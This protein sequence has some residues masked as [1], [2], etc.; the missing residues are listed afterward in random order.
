MSLPGQWGDGIMIAC[1][2]KLYERQ[3]IILLEDGS[4]IEFHPH[5]QAKETTGV[6]LQ[7]LTFGFVKS[8]GAK[9]PDH[10]V[11]LQKKTYASL[12]PSISGS[13]SQDLVSH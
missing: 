6:D 10:F 12:S 3:I 1:A 2:S 4:V 5:E 13:S 8:L 9:N 11:F 7:S